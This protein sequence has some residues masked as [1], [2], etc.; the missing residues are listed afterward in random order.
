MQTEPTQAKISKP[1]LVGVVASDDRHI[2][3][4]LAC[5]HTI[6]NGLPLG[7]WANPPAKRRRCYKCAN[8]GAA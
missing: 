1:P 4:T 6:N 8:G 7:R 2:V 5:G 3:E